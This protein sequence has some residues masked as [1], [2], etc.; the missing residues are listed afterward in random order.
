MGCSASMVRLTGIIGHK[1]YLHEIIVICP[2]E[3]LTTVLLV[4][5]RKAIL[6]GDVMSRV[7]FTGFRRG[8][9]G[10]HVQ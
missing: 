10:M 8:G 5:F 6:N 4:R 3:S 2:V 7:E 1:E 9:S